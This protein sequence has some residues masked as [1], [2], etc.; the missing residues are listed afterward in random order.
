MACSSETDSGQAN[1]APRL[2]RE[3]QSLLGRR[4]DPSTEFRLWSLRGEGT[5]VRLTIG[6]QPLQ[7]SKVP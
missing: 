3:L 2:V 5:Q 4:A 6:V 7:P 1:V